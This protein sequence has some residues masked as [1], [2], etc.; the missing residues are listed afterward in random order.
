MAAKTVLT[1]EESMRLVQWGKEN[2][3]Y[4]CRNPRNNI[5]RKIKTDTGIDAGL[6][7]IIELEKMYKV[8]KKHGG[9]RPAGKNY[10]RLLLD[11]HTIAVAV[12][13]LYRWNHATLNDDGNKKVHTEESMRQLLQ[14]RNELDTSA[15]A[16]EYVIRNLHTLREQIR[17]ERPTNTSEGKE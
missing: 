12:H 14:L 11:L 8:T 7:K 16:V 3:Q 4:M 9:K 17:N 10:S 5:R 6:T 2:C 15:D 1:M 13:N